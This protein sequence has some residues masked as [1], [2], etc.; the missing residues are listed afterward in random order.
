MHID[1]RKEGHAEDSMVNTF[2]GQLKH[3]VKGRFC[4]TH[5][6]R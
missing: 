2:L 3:L 4:V 6:T 1:S 5:V